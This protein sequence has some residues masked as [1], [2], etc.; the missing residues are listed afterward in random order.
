ML[1]NGK[2]VVGHISSSLKYLIKAAANDCRFDPACNKS[3]EKCVSSELVRTRK[4][5]SSSVLGPY[6]RHPPVTAISSALQKHR[7]SPGPRRRRHFGTICTLSP[8]G[9]AVDVPARG[10]RT[11]R[12]D[13]RESGPVINISDP[14]L[15]RIGTR[16]AVILKGRLDSILARKRTEGRRCKRN[17]L[18]RGG[19]G[20]SH[21]V[22]SPSIDLLLVSAS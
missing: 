15:P 3:R 5:L 9:L 19:W 10:T 22:A 8:A 14:S 20:K 2:M 12:A 11:S 13:R 18:G 1:R 4:A 6:G 17:S 21:L 7:R 16:T